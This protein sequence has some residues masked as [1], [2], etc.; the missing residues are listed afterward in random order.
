ML[1]TFSLPLAIIIVISAL[2]LSRKPVSR[3]EILFCNNVP[4]NTQPRT[5]T[6]TDRNLPSQGQYTLAD[7]VFTNLVTKIHNAEH[8]SL[9][10]R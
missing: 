10:E 8:P 7:V 6:D 9:M 1:F 4:L 2:S 3:D 5:V